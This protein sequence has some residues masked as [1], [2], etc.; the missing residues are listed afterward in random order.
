MQDKPIELTPS[1]PASAGHSDTVRAVAG[2]WSTGGA[3]RV[4]S[5]SSD[6]TLRIWEA[7]D[8]GGAPVELAALKG[9]TGGVFCLTTFGFDEGRRTRLVSGS[10]DNTLRIWDGSPP[11]ERHSLSQSPLKVLVG[12][13][14]TVSAVMA[15]CDRVD[16][17]VPSWRLLSADV[18]ELRLWDPVAGAGL[19][20]IA[21]ETPVHALCA[22][23]GGSTFGGTCVAWAAGDGTVGTQ[24][25]LTGDRL[26][27]AS[28]AIVTRAHSG[29]TC[30]VASCGRGRL[31]SCGED[32][33]V[34]VHD[35]A[36]SKAA[37]R[38]RRLPGHTAEVNAVVAFELLAA[39]AGAMGIGGDWFVVS[40]SEDRSLRLW[41]PVGGTALAVLL[42]HTHPV[43]GAAVRV[44]G[45]GGG[46][47]DGGVRI[48][49][50]GEDSVMRTWSPPQSALVSFAPA[51]T[52]AATAAA[53]APP[54]SSMAAGDA[55]AEYVPLACSGCGAPLG[56]LQAD[57]C[58][59]AVLRATLCAVCHSAR[60]RGGGG[61]G[62]GDA[63]QRAPTH[64]H[65]DAGGCECCP[66]DRAEGQHQHGHGHHQ[67]GR[68]M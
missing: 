53:A 12:H 29:S 3:W 41:D 14:A 8:S 24:A 9:H 35:A 52:E 10:F 21:L 27:T 40:C 5:G 61:G 43:L 68:Y 18:K 64:E 26:A 32:G 42:G 62:G 55:A 38:P 49:S 48:V 2:Y 23:D 19:G 65:S 39:G 4:A 54:P 66:Q 57:V 22:F 50:G 51:A 7:P 56:W 13:R 31:V 17:A 30:G 44:G 6:S 47:A 25:M 1:A 46:G 59:R 63:A 34:C 33:M 45:G 20:V 16:A 37:A 67:P 36:G 28:A 58:S 60:R 15:F 11:V